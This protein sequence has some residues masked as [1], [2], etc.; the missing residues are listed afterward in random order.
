MSYLT[1]KR[2]E[3]PRCVVYDSNIAVIPGV[4][5]GTMLGGQ[6]PQCQTDDAEVVFISVT[7][8]V[9]ADVSFEIFSSTFLSPCNSFSAFIMCQVRL[10]RCLYFLYISF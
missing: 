8:W 2:E 10:S 3:R 4:K 6:E 5:G 1:V 9:S 7:F